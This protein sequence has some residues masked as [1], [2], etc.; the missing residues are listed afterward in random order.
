VSR[1][2]SWARA[3]LV[4]ASSILGVLLLE[5]IV[6][7]SRA[8]EPRPTGY[9]PVATDFRAGRPRN[10]RGYRDNERALSK[11]SGVRRLLVLGDSFSWGASV[12][13]EDAWPQRLERGL[14]RRRGEPWEVVT[15]ALPGLALN[16]YAAQL[17][18]EGMEYAPDAIAIGY[19]L[20][21]A[22][23]KRAMKAR[24]AGYVESDRRDPFLERSAL[25]RFVAGR[26]RAT[27]IARER[28][29]YHRQLYDDKNPDW[30]EAKAALQSIGRL[31][32]ERG[33][34]WLVVLFP[35]FGN[36]LDDSYPFF[37]AHRKVTL[38]AEKD[39]A[40][41][42][43]LFPAYRGLRADLLVVDGVRDEHPNEIAHRIAAGAA[44][45]ALD[46]LLPP[47]R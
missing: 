40:K 25:Y 5:G 12:E 46:E 28:V 34:P 18:A 36:P 39:G 22:E 7:L 42:L 4:A 38:E 10:A 37:E 9:A 44:L 3:A 41:V 17:A 23:S 13:F 47:S 11:A 35:L 32:R 31:S 16:D 26:L 30:G 1:G 6:R 19:C 8:G 20:N 24:E 15:L 14:A 27:A 2:S 45:R 43:D 21:D 29:R 33:V